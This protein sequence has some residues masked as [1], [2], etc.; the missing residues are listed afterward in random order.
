[1]LSLS[2][3]PLQPLIAASILSADFG[4]V[5][6][7]VGDVIAKGA[8]LVHIDVM[9]GHFVDNLTVGPAMVRALRQAFPGVYLDVHLMV[10]RPDR[11]I[12]AFA[13]AGANN[14]TFQV[15]V[16]QPHGEGRGIEGGGID[17]EALIG[18]A[19]EHGMDAGLALNP[20]TPIE[21]IQPYLAFLDLVL[22]MSVLPGRGG[23][24]FM[25]EV[26]PKAQWVQQVIDRHTRVE[27]D[28]GLN[29]DTS[30]GAVA[31]GVD[32]LVTGSSLFKAKDRAVV[33]DAMHQSQAIL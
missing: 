7:E 16:C 23:Q 1:M 11:F 27:M 4:R 28:G 31:A 6:E 25:P 22:V 10:E 8:D 15:E 33:I 12:D 3:P 30:P 5:A 14:F 19:H 17:G 26:L 24:A 20:P 32:V 21:H 13:K 29:P 2:E 18:R 9:D